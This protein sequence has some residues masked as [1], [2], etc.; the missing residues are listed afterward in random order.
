MKNKVMELV[1]DNV[2]IIS[3]LIMVVGIVIIDPS[4]FQIRVLKDILV[5]SSVKIII[6]LGLMLVL[7]VGG[8]DLSGGRQVGLAA[9]IVASMLQ[10]SDYIGKFYPNLPELPIIVPVVLVL[11]ILSVVG[12][13]NGFLITK[14]KMAPFIATF[15][16]STIVF[17][18]NSLYYALEPNRSQPIGGIRK[19]FTQISNYKLFGSISPLIPISIFFIILIWIILNKTKLGKNIY[20]IGGNKEAALV[21]G[22]KVTQIMIG[23]F[24]IESLLLGVGGILEVARSGGANSAYGLGYEFDAIS[25][26]VVGGVS[27]KGG[28]GKVSG[29]VIGVLV[30][31]LITYGLAYI[32]INPNWQ[33]VIKGIIIIVAIALDAK[34]TKEM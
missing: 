25:A 7:L 31:T 33:Q 12:F 19:D 11:L 30:F 3:L 27:L 24:I 20:A 16:M 9:V 28:I 32:G 4:F 26:C 8:T 2:L 21:S 23:V 18:I 14:F 6:A 17:G 1:K 15:A 29:T 13:V 5:Q 34:K 10:T 22:I